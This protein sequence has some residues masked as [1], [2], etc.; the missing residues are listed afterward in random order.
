[1]PVPRDREVVISKWLQYRNTSQLALAEAKVNEILAR[2]QQTEG[3]KITLIRERFAYY[4][5]LDVTTMLEL[6]I[7][8]VNIV[9]NEQDANTRQARRRSFGSDMN[10]IIPRVLEYLEG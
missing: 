8:R 6:A 2:P 3:Q 5:R 10:I 7:W 1:M 9:G 4:D